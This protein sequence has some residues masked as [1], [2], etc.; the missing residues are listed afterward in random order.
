ML[1]ASLMLPF[2][3]LYP[4]L[5][6][7]L[8]LLL[9]TA[10]LL[11][12]FL[13]NQTRFVTGAT[14]V[15]RAAAAATASDAEA[16]GAAPA[17]MAAGRCELRF[18]E[19]APKE[20]MDAADGVAAC[21]PSSWVGRQHNTQQSRCVLR[22]DGSVQWLLPSSSPWQLSVPS[23]A[24]T[25]LQVRHAALGYNS[26]YQSMVSA[27]TSHDSSAGAAHDSI[28]KNQS[29]LGAL[30]GYESS[31]GAGLGSNSKHQSMVSALTR[32]HESLAGAAG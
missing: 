27:L 21:G 12:L 24:M 8:L 3:L 15:P 29:M 32:S 2:N 4:L 20:A 11:L 14:A 25:Y 10:L 7:L 16:A 28:S 26:Q 23:L 5:L 6:L 1:A 22:S 9:A 30:T 17:A 31:A 13:P 19:A 18:S